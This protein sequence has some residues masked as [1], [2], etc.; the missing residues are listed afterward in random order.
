MNLQD[1]DLELQ[2]MEYKCGTWFEYRNPECMRLKREK[3]AARVASKG[4]LQNLQ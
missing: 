4:N 1:L 3:N 2:N